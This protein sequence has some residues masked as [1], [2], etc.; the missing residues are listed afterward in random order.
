[1]DNRATPR[2]HAH[3][4]DTHRLPTQEVI[5]FDISP[6]ENTA[7]SAIE[8]RLGMLLRCPLRETGEVDR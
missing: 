6:P 3:R 5:P 2:N 1:C 7:H 4:R 8:A